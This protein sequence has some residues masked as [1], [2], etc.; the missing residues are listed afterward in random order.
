MPLF[1]ITDKNLE[2]I[3]EKP[4]LLER[5]LQEL[6]ENNLNRVFG[7]EFVKSEFQINNFRIDTLA[8]DRGSDAF[9]IIE[10]KRDKNFT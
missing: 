4:F 5:E 9:V 2:S 1:K 6:T 7:L 3:K 8:F 10:F